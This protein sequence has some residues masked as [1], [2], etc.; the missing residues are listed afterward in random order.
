MSIAAMPVAVRAISEPDATSHKVRKPPSK[1]QAIALAD[2]D[3][4]PEPR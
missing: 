3:M 2:A 1:R 4:R